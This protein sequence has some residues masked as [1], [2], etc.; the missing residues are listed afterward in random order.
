MCCG[1]AASS[2]THIRLLSRLMVVHCVAHKLYIQSTYDAQ[3]TH[4]YKQIHQCTRIFMPMLIIILVS[5]KFTH[6]EI[7]IRIWRIDN[8]YTEQLVHCVVGLQ[9]RCTRHRTALICQINFLF[10][11]LHKSVYMSPHTH[12]HKKK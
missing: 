5:L 10:D 9:T 11:S 6:N 8:P 12:T 3:S 2:A 1:H 4:S 7:T